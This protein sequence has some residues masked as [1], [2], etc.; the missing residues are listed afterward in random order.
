MRSS[1]ILR[2]EPTCCRAAW[3]PVSMA[4]PTQLDDAGSPYAANRFL[5]AMLQLGVKGREESQTDQRTGEVEQALEQIRSPFIAHTQATATE[6]PGERPLH[7][8]PM[9]SQPLAGVDAATGKPRRDAPSTQ[10]APQGQGVVG[11]VGVELGRALPRTTRL[12]PRAGDGGNGINEP[13]ELGRIVDIG[14]QEEDGQRET[15]AIH[16]QVVLGT[17]LATVG[18]I[19]AGLF[20]PLLAPML[21]LSRLARLQSTAASSPSQLRSRVCNFSQTPGSC[22]SRSRRQQVVPLPQPSTFG[23][24]RQGQPVRNTKMI[25]PSA[26]RSGT[27]GRPPFGLGGSLGNRGSMASHR[28]SETSGSF[29]A[30]EEYEGPTSFATRSK[31]VSEKGSSGE[32]GEHEAAHGEVDPGLFGGG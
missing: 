6:Q 9:P 30:R 10:R 25:P 26:A 5:P 2:P 7:H 13:D 1:R 4:G 21:R 19:G 22:Q 28:S 15:I 14:R 24:S 8:P 32:S 27:R 18:R 29:I 11:L 17:R 23:R 31:R 20:A 3:G 12:A 16:H